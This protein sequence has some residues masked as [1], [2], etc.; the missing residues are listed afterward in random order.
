MKGIKMNDWQKRVVEEKKE[1]D[2]RINKLSNFNKSVNY[3][4]LSTEDQILLDSQLAAM[5][6]YS[7]I[8]NR[9]INTFTIKENAL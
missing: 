2:A 6:S 3:N 7:D 1:L 8:L 5:L 4:K 9:R